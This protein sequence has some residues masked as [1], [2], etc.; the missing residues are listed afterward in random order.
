MKLNIFILSPLIFFT[1]LAYGQNDNDVIDATQLSSQVKTSVQEKDLKSDDEREQKTVAQSNSSIEKIE[2]TGSYVRRIDI[3]G[4]S[5]VVVINKEEFDDAG[6]DTVSDYL[7]E[8]AMFTGSTDSGDRDGYFRFR[9]QHAGSTLVLINGMRVPKLG[10][11]GRGFYAGVE[12]IPTN[13]IE[14]VEV[15]KDGSSALYGSDAMAGVMNYITKKDYDGAE[16]ATRI[17]VPEIN[18][19]LQQNHTIS[20]GKSYSR[21]SWFA[22]TQYV[23]QRGYTERDAGNYFAT[24]TVRPS[25]SGAWKT[26]DN[27]SGGYDKGTRFQ[28]N[29]ASDPNSSACPADNRNIDFVRD[30]RE[31]IGT[32]LS[33]RYDI[34]SNVSASLIAIYNRRQ[35]MDIGRPTYINIGTNQGDP[36]INVAQLGSKELKL[37]SNGKN[38]AELSL[39]PID[40]VGL[41]R[42]AILQNSYAAQSKVE[43]YYL[44]TW[45]WDLSSSYAYSLEERDHQNGLV[46]K[47]GVTAALYNGWNPMAVGVQNRGALDSAKVQGTEAYEA[48]QATARLLTTGELFE[49]ND[50]WGTGGPVSAAVGIEGQWET[51]ADVHDAILTDTSLNAPFFPN[52]KGSRAVSS[53]FLELVAYPLNALEVQLAGRYDRYSDFGD[54]FNPKISMGF[55]PSNKVLFR[56]SWGTNFNAPSVRNMIE[57]DSLN[58]EKLQLCDQ[59]DTE[60]KKVT[61]QTTRYREDDL[62]PETGVNYN[63][64]TV[65]QPNKNWSFTIDQ[66]NFEGNDTL[67]KVSAG[68]YNA[69]YQSFGPD[70]DQ[71]MKDIGVTIV[72]NNDGSISSIQIPSVTNM[73][74]RTIRG[75]DINVAFNSPIKIFGRV[76]RA[77][78]KMDHTHMLVYKTKTAPQL[79]YVYRADLEWKNTSSLALSSMRHSYRFAAR[80]LAGDTGQNAS[81]RTHTE[82][83]LNY[84]YKI[85]FWVAK[86]S[87]GIKNILNSRP[88]VD[89]S[90]SFVDFTNGYNTYAFQALGRRYY[91]G[92]NHSF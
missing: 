69:I 3:E 7:R 64:G 26:F 43:G 12:S 87:F 60:C 1:S 14:R 2:V 81:T 33:G 73:G 85:P 8:N 13:I 61:T 89:R 91:V 88:P 17:N 5:P 19:G 22:S 25:S 78:A 71:K 49:M 68:A 77:R 9:G 47:N 67:S 51:T 75:L 80:T 76:L 54:T 32:I 30:R 11:P 58:Y 35:R 27:A 31:N 53:M 6:V 44:D 56:S 34:N 46:S 52:Q 50:V 36:R 20:F 79:D 41:S 59:S 16:Y 65:I 38:Y 28:Q 42:V 70:A 4:P 72:R 66:W 63:F 10:G 62:Q 23:E 83:D 92:Y 86:L 37:S 48:T 15:L 74:Q 18:Q 45:K 39:N 57:R 24:E 82:F 21:G 90:R 40:E 29:C 55:R 84:T